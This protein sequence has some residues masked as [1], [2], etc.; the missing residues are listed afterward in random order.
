M[1]TNSKGVRGTSRV[2]VGVGVGVSTS[3]TSVTSVR[4]DWAARRM[5]EVLMRKNEGLIFTCEKL[6]KDPDRSRTVFKEK[7]TRGDLER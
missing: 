5:A 3:V 4:S 2:G 7:F 6:Q 1:Q